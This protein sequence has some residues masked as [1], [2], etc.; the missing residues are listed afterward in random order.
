[1][2][3][4]NFEIQEKRSSRR[5]RALLKLEYRLAADQDTSGAFRPAQASDISAAGIKFTCPE[6]V[7]AGSLVQLRLSSPYS[8]QSL[9]L[10]G[11]VVRASR[12]E[13]KT[14][15]IGVSF[16]QL[17]EKE[18]LALEQQLKLLD[19]CGLLE[20]MGKKEASDLHLTTG[21]P[22]AFR[23][24]GDL[25][26]SHGH[27]LTAQ[28]IQE[29]VYSLMTPEQITEFEENKEL[30]YA[31][32]LPGIGRRRVN[33]HIQRGSVEATYRI[34]EM[35]IR[36]IQDLG[37]PP[38]VAELARYKD[39][40]VIV[41]GP[42]GSGKSTT[43]AAMVDLIN[44]D[45]RKVIVTLEDPI[46]FL[47]QNKRSIVKQ[48]EIGVDTLSFHTG[49]RH[50]VRQ[51]PNV[52][53]IGECR[54]LET[55]RVVLTAAET[56]HLVM[57]TLHTSD[58]VQ[59]IARVLGLFPPDQRHIAQLQLSNSLR[60]VICQQLLRKKDNLGRVV[61]TE[62]LIG[63]PAIKALIRDGRLEQILTHIQTGSKFGMQTRQASIQQ[64]NERGLIKKEEFER[65]AR[66]TRD[67]ALA[68]Y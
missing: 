44:S 58:A 18:R 33:V 22:P 34:I 15:Q 36:S 14:Y 51:D 42:T 10:A 53:L 59:T 47:H 50:V 23:V 9:D 6:S 20:E 12:E 17:R 39:G 21:R 48:R 25:S 11:K 1:M 55:M 54:D 49:L 64:L 62:V 3:R 16:G 61:A 65:A 29:M 57:T 26:Y 19:I 60:G 8:N 2:A 31:I 32:S 5:I 4:E 38:V 45:F 56:G 13:G 43:L 27:E 30:N 28:E 40:L 67:L 66:Y 52:I 35:N 7:S 63:T 24:D 41:A 46:E 68:E 37:L